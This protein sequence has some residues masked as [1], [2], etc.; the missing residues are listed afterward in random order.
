VTVDGICKNVSDK[1]AISDQPGSEDRA[2]LIRA[3]NEGVRRVLLA[4]RINVEA[5]TLSLV[6]DT[7]EYTLDTDILALVDYVNTDDNRSTF[8]IAPTTE[9]LYR[10][11]LGAQGAARRFTLIGGNKL[12]VQPTPNEDADVTLYAVTQPAEFVTNGGDDPLTAAVPE[13]AQKAVEWWMCVE[14]A[15]KNKDFQTTEY[16]SALY[17]R[18]IIKVRKDSRWL[19]GRR[20]APM[21][22]S[23]P[24]RPNVRPAENSQDEGY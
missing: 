16:Y 23:Y 13:Y 10:R 24:E 12:I 19:A 7:S 14:G 5:V 17:D 22:A 18:E 6:A 9:V 2:F 4:T 1:L 8:T 15:Q 20:L 3:L 11:L 21:Q